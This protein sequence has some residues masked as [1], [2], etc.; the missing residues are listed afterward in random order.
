MCETIFHRHSQLPG[1]GRGGGALRTGGAVTGYPVRRRI[2]TSARD[3]PQSANLTQSR[4]KDEVA[5][6]AAAGKKRKRSLTADS[7]RAAGGVR[8]AGLGAP[9]SD[10]Y[11]RRPSLLCAFAEV[12][13]AGACGDLYINVQALYR[14]ASK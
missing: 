1:Y 9:V 2:S 10:V 5:A 13:T 7:R 3:D 6:S 14:C 11:P 8:V 12:E 4:K